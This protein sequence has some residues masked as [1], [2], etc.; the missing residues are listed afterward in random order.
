[1]KA[2]VVLL[3]LVVAFTASAQTGRI[4]EVR[5]QSV[6]N[7]LVSTRQ[8][9]LALF[10]ENGGPDDLLVTLCWIRGIA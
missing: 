9:S 10:A 2:L 4:R 5:I 8:S 6:E 1:M 3:E 7:D